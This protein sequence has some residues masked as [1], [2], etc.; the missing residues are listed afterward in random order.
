[1][2]TEEANFITAEIV[3]SEKNINKDIRILN[4]YEEFLKTAPKYFSKDESNNNEEEI[5]MC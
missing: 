3:I 4:S 5:K 1:M 2:S